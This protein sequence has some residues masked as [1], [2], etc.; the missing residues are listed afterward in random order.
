MAS[1]GTFAVHLVF[2]SFTSSSILGLLQHLKIALIAFEDP[3]SSYYKCVIIVLACILIPVI[4]CYYSPQGHLQSANHCV[5]C[6]PLICL[7]LYCFLGCAHSPPNPFD[8]PPPYPISIWQR[9]S[10]SL[11]TYAIFK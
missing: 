2:I 3:C 9:S 4:F 8:Y 1:Y 7:P 5:I 6:P 11:Y 10:P